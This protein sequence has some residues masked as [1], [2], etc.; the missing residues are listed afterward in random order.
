M[1]VDVGGD[2]DLVEG[3]LDGVGEDGG[4]GGEDTEAT[5]CVFETGSG[6]ELSE[7]GG[8]RC[9]VEVA[10][11]DTGSVVGIGPVGGILELG[12]AGRSILGV[13]GR[14]GV[15]VENMKWLT[16]VGEGGGQGGN[17]MLVLECVFDFFYGKARELGEAEHVFAGDDAVA[18]IVGGEGF[19]FFEPV[20]AHFLQHDKVRVFGFDEVEDGLVVGV[21]GEDVAEE[22]LDGLGIRVWGCAGGEVDRKDEGEM[23]G[24]SDEGEAGPAIV[25]K[26]ELAHGEGQPGTGVEDDEVGGDF[27]GP[28]EATDKGDGEEEGG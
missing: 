7:I 11:D 25:F 16:V 14:Q 9:R 5:S 17:A 20:E 10:D 18:G 4:P 27:E 24:R 6:H 26:E 28:P 21:V 8:P 22:E 13:T 19:E 1:D 23:D 3:N 15:H 12:I 2:E